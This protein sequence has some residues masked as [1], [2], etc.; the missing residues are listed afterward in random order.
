MAYQVIKALKAENVQ[1]VVAPYEADAQLAFLEDRG[2]VD[3]IVTEDSDLLVFGC[4]HVLFKLDS[5]GNCVS[6]KR[7]MFGENK[8]A[9]LVGWSDREFRW[10]AVSGPP[11]RHRVT[12]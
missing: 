3:G 4:K 1:Y 10:M 11:D 8:E 7:E 9:S 6:V 12:V 2:L 5:D